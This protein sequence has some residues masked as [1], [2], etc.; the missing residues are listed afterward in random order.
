MA[1]LP[2]VSLYSE[3]LAVASLA[4]DGGVTSMAS[5]IAKL[6]QVRSGEPLLG[7]V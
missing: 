4:L 1:N 7:D 6:V 3:R 2:A 5:R